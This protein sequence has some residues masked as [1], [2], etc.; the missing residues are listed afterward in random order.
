MK[1]HNIDFDR[2]INI[3][4]EEFGK[5]KANELVRAN[6]HKLNYLEGFIIGLIKYIRDVFNDYQNKYGKKK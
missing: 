1:H 6:I 4:S 5:I 2:M 3:V